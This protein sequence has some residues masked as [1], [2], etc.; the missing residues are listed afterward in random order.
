MY[1]Y[2]QNPGW[3]SK[4]HGLVPGPELVEKKKKKSLRIANRE[5][6]PRFRIAA[7]DDLDAYH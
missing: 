2:V 5:S 3:G 1:S 6:G 4:R 7:E